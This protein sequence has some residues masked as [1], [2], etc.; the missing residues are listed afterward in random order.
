MP[1]IFCPRKTRKTWRG[2]TPTTHTDG[3][4]TGHGRDTDG[5]RT[6]DRAD[7]SDRYNT[8]HRRCLTMLNPWP[9]VGNPPKT[10][11]CKGTTIR[12]RSAYMPITWSFL[13]KKSFTKKKKFGNSTD[14]TRTADRTDRY[15]P[16]PALRKCVGDDM[17]LRLPS[18]ITENSKNSIDRISDVGISSA[19]RN[20]IPIQNL[21]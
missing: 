16:R 18:S 13:Y 20:I 3:T 6:A 2:L 10:V 21:S 1:P 7:W 17:E 14:G 4:R 15:V 11:P 5:I 9:G 19:R 12:H 8:L